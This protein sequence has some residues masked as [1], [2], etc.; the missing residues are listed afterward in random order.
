MKKKFMA[1][2][3]SLKAVDE[4]DGEGI[5]KGYASVFNNVDYGLDVIEKGAFR[6]TLMESKGKVPILADHNPSKQVGYN[7]VAEEDD[8]GLYIEGRLDVKNNQLARERFSLAKMALE[9]GAKFGFSIGYITI[10]EEPDTDNPMIR[11]LKEL[12]LLE[13]S[14]VTF[15]MNKEAGLTGAKS[16]Y[17][18]M[19]DSDYANCIAKLLDSGKSKEEILEALNKAAVKIN[20]PSDSEVQL[21]ISSIE[22]AKS[23]FN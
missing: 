14:M 3:F 4:E 17:Q 18:I 12:K 16:E 23:I 22:K 2:P 9:I 8:K 15:P 10:K 1:M 11:R 5:I 7:L 19:N 21:L 6:K 20:N 13:Y